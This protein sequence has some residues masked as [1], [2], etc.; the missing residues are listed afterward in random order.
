MFLKVAFVEDA[1]VT[2]FSYY[3][4]TDAASFAKMLKVASKEFRYNFRKDGISHGG[5]F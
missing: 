5:P 1:T 2:P 3:I 4:S